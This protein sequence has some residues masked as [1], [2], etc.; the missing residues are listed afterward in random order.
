MPI[1]VT[2]GPTAVL[3]SSSS[4]R[5]AKT[6]DARP[7]GPNQPTSAT[8]GQPSRAPARAAA[9]GTIRITVRLSTA[10]TMIC[11]VRPLNADATATAPN[12]SQT[13]SD[14]RAPASST[15]GT[16]G[17]PRRPPVVPNASPPVNAAMK[18]L[19][20]SASAHAYAHSASA[21]TAEPAK[22]SAAQPR[23]RVAFTSTP[24]APPTATPITMPMCEL[25]GGDGWSYADDMLGGS[26]ARQGDRHE[27]RG[28]AVIEPALDVDQPTNPG[29]H[30]GVGHHSRAKRCVRGRQGRA[31]DQGEPNVGDPGQRQC[32]QR[33][34]GDRERKPDPEQP[35]VQAEVGPQPMQPDPGRVAEQHQHEGDLRQRLDHLTTW[36]DPE[37]RQRS[38]GKNQPRAHER[39]RRG[40][41]EPFQPRRQCT[42]GE[43]Q[44]RHDRQVR[45]AHDLAQRIC[46]RTE[47]MQLPS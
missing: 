19:P 22:P 25:R 16:S 47:S 18:P 27:R 11:H 13:S 44:R 4:A 12:A 21:S 37:G 17:A 14:A 1:T 9:T 41:F 39:D 29:G 42:P 3:P 2:A 31:H 43:Y 6:T 23:R 7:R 33:S 10:Y 15:N 38:M 20:C 30:Y 24:P 34:Q 35:Q 32:E 26:R 8:V 45:I 5:R 36:L 46:A 28:D 40:N